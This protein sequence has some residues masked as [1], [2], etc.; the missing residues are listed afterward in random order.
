VLQRLAKLFVVLSLTLSLGAHW[1]FLQSVAWFGMVVSYSQHNP[2]LE[3]VSKTFDG[4]HPCGL[5]K[6]VQAGKAKEKKQDTAKPKT[7]LDQGLVGAQSVALFPPKLERL[8]PA[9][10]SSPDSRC[11]SPPTPPPERA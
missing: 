11:E 7:K 6:F 10:S 2:L 1:M 5:C 3:A 8:I 4:K 9:H